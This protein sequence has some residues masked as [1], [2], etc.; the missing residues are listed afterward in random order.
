MSTRVAVEGPITAA[1]LAAVSGQPGDLADSLYTAWLQ[2]ARWATVD[3]TI[4]VFDTFVLGR[5]DPFLREVAHQLRLIRRAEARG[6]LLDE[7]GRFYEEHEH[8]DDARYEPPTIADRVIGALRRYPDSDRLLDES[9][10]GCMVAVLHG[11]DRS[12][13]LS[14]IRLT[15]AME[16]LVLE[17]ADAIEIAGAVVIDG[18]LSGERADSLRR[19]A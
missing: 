12:T 11:L 5:P 6:D 7:E 1:L 9:R 8:D 14:H 10:F 15:L 19:V 3:D 18:R 13:W 17:L 2:T 16:R 4:V